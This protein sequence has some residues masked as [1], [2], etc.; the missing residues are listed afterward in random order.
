MTRIFSFLSLLL[1]VTHTQADYCAESKIIEHQLAPKDLAELQ[2][3][4]LAGS[5]EITASEDDQLHFWGKACTS[6]PKY[7][8]RM[9]VIVSE[10]ADRLIFQTI[11]PHHRDDFDPSYASIDIELQVPGSLA[12]R[13]ED[14]SGD[15]LIEDVRVLSVDD[16]SGD[17]RLI[18]TTSDLAIRDSSGKIS[19]REH[20]GGIRIYDSSGPIDLRDVQGDITIPADSSGDIKI[21]QV[22]GHVTIESDGSGDIDIENITG[23]V[24]V[25]SDGSGDID[26][27]SVSGSIEISSDGSGSIDVAEIAGSFKV[28]NKGSGQILHRGVDGEIDVP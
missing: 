9:D 17:I 21:D 23:D 6:E 2:M 26:V 12:V 10:E 18:N 19:V 5:L 16:S 24:L 13:V 8:E 11:I 14:S 27:E 7:L 25:G 15:T 22:Q 3:Q 20:A 1:V 4:A 28:V